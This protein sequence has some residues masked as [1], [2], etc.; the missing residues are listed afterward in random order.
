MRNV[1]ALVVVVVSIG[2]ALTA[3]AQ[4]VTSDPLARVRPGQAVWVTAFDG[5]EVQG[6]V[7][8]VSTASL[9]VT[10]TAGERSIPMA[11][12]RTIEA[13]DSRG[14]GAR[15]GALIGAAS[16]GV[17]VGLLGY[18]LRCESDCGPDYSATRDTV[19]GVL[20]GAGFGAGGGALLG[21]WIDGLVKGR[22]AL[23]VAPASRSMTWEIRP[24][25]SGARRQVSMTV[26]W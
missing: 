19:E 20:F 5:T 9:V 17:Y 1:A 12:V 13:P 24:L 4:D 18:A 11:T 16:L 26:R 2:W 10:D 21:L 7:V 25:I 6:R 3:T 14:N 23:Y 15:N 22:Q 8:T